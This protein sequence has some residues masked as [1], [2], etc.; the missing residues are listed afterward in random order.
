MVYICYLIP[1][2]CLSAIYATQ[3]DWVECGNYS[4]KGLDYDDN[5]LMLLNH[6]GVAMC[7]QGNRDG[8]QY[9]EKGR[10]LGDA[11]CSGNFNYWEQRL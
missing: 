7:K 9:L 5:N 2:L 4:L 8:L 3:D 10:L 1:Y 11:S 6:L